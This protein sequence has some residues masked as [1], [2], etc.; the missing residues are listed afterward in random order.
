[1]KLPLVV[2]VLARLGIVNVKGLLQTVAN[3]GHC[4][5][6]SFSLDHP[7]TGSGQHGFDDDPLA[8]VVFAEYPVR[9]FCRQ[10]A[11]ESAR[12]TP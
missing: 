12:R 1:L 5:G 9:G 10:A 11:Q 8:G 2:F 6:C 7:H 4:L 3:R